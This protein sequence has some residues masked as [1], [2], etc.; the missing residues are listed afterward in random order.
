MITPPSNI[1][2][3]DVVGQFTLDK[4]DSSDPDID[5]DFVPARG[6]V[7]FTASTKY[8]LDATAVPN[9]ATIL[10]TTIRAILDSD[11]YLCTPTAPT[12]NVP[13]RRGIR[14]IATDDE[15]LNPTGWV[16]NVTYSLL[17]VDD[18]QLGAPASHQLAVP[19]G[20]TRDLTTAIPPENAQ[21]IGIPQAEAAAALSAAYALAAQQSAAAAEAALIDSAEFVGT[22]ISTPGTP[23]NDALSSTIGT[24]GGELFV[25]SSGPWDI[26][27]VAGQSNSW[28]TDFPAFNNTTPDPRVLSYTTATGVVAQTPAKNDELGFAFARAYARDHL[29]L[30]RNVVTTRNGYGETG[31]SSTSITPAPAGYTTVPNGTWDRALTADPLNRALEVISTAQAVLAIAPPNSRIVALVWSQGE[32]DRVKIISSGE[33]WYQGKLDDFFGWVRTTLALPSLP[34]VVMSQTPETVVGSTGGLAVNRVHEGTPSRLKW[35]TYVYGPEGRTKTDEDVHFTTPGHTLR[36]QMASDAYPKALLNNSVIRPGQPL[37][38][39]VQILGTVAN[40]R[41][42][43]PTQRVTSYML[44]FSTD[45]GATWVTVSLAHL[46]AL[47]AA[48]S[49]PQNAPVWARVRSANEFTSPSAWSPIATAFGSVPIATPDPSLPPVLTITDYVNRWAART[50]SYGSVPALVPAKGSISLVQAVAGKQP[51][52]LDESGVK[53]IRFDG[54]DD[55]LAGT[56]A[57]AKTITVVVKPKAAVGVNTALFSTGPNLVRRTSEATPRIGTQVN[58][59]TNEFQAYTEGTKFH[60]ITL[61]A[62]GTTGAVSIDGGYATLNGATLNTAVILGRYGTT[63]FGQVDILDVLTWDRALSSAECATV[64]TDLSAGYPGLVA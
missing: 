38:L 26:V 15:D 27:I 52:V 59:G 16:W 20:E 19:A 60:V 23:A 45:L 13:A 22:E 8:L 55:D 2:Y 36:G 64:R 12:S 46:M 41:W 14:L 39:R 30:G 9:P 48:I 28:E 50:Q 31:F 7:F 54:V 56:V 57:T 35:S 17:D 61:I 53:L 10:R 37:N 29:Q 25:T 32:Q 11:G 42:D 49:I 62:D 47:S 44:Q 24:V 34:I 43:P 4:I 58:G 63:N 1:S 5:P 51:S 33:S 21:T 18:R 40:V 6:E 3:G